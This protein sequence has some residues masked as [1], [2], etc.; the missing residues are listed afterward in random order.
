MVQSETEKIQFEVIDQYFKS[1][2]FVEHH[3]RS[4]DNF[5]EQDIKKTLSDLN[6]IDFSVGF[7]KKQQK[8]ENLFWR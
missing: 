7:V 6:P 5:Y 2:S 1:N 3:I 4:V 8:Y